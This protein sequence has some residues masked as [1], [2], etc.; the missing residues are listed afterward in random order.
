M[1]IDQTGW[2][3]ANKAGRDGKDY[4][5]YET[6]ALHL[7]PI[8]RRLSWLSKDGKSRMPDYDPEHSRSHLQLLCLVGTT[9]KVADRHEIAYVA[10]AVVSVKGKGQ[11]EAIKDALSTWGRSIDGLRVGM[12]AKG[13]PLFAWWMTIGTRGDA[14]FVR[15][16]TGSTTGEVTPVKALMATEKLTAEQMGARFIG[17]HTFALAADLLAQ[18]MEWLAAW[19][20]P[21]AALMPAGAADGGGNGGGGSYGTNV[22]EPP[23]DDSDIPF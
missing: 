18:A 17:R 10:P 3:H 12:N 23:M 5:A 22:A 14:D 9:I 15:M 2:T 19:K 11:T 8:G 20:T 16:G 21:N 6:R 4:E 7:A 13:V 1:P